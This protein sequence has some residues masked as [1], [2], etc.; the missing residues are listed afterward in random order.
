M[1]IVFVLL[2]AVAVW[3]QTAAP[4]GK[5][6]EVASI[7]PSGEVGPGELTVGLHIDGAQVRGHFFTLKDYLAIA[8]KLKNYQISGPDWIA[9]ERYEI[10]AKM[11]EGATR[12]QVPEMLQALL[13][14]RFQIQ[15]HHDTKQEQVYGL[16]LAKSG[17]KM[18]PL[19]D[20]NDSDS[21]NSAVDMVAGGSKNGVSINMGKGSSFS[22]GEDKFMAK[23]I[24]MPF[25]ADMLARFVERP[26]VDMTGT[27]GSY[28][29]TLQFSPEDFR[30]MMI[31]S[32]VSAGVN[33]PPQAL[34]LLN[35]T[36]DAGLL[37]EL[38][39]L[40]LTLESRKAPIDMLV[41]DRA[42]K[43]PTEN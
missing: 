10:T 11:P 12:Q 31:R 13:T 34:Q 19:P 42:E 18:Q 30:T 36:S 21:A 35:G 17:L 40:G 26:V 43:T 5:E 28:D 4:S 15:S 16:L 39:T 23:K 7:R 20:S 38:R 32:A 33:L 14:S 29:F 6:F 37:T 24:T 3:A 8:Y 1:K 27:K 41:I 25:L 2:S 22:F 9:S